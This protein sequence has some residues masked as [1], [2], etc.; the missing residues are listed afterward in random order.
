MI[1]FG[2]AC[3]NLTLG[4][5]T[6]HTLRL[7]KLGDADRLRGAVDANITAAQRIIAW[8]GANGYHLFRLG[9]SFIP[10]ASHENF[11]YD[12]QREHGEQLR[13]LA[14]LAR[15]HRQRLSMHPG[16]YCNPGSPAAGVV[17]RSLAELRYAAALI[18]LL[19]PDS[20]VIVIHLG[21]VFGD[22]ASAV[23]RFVD[24]LRPQRDILRH[25]ALE[26]DETSWSID[27]VLP[28]ASALGVPVIVDNLHHRLNPG[29][30]TLRGALAQA[31]TTWTKRPKV[32]LS[33]QAD[34][35]PVG[36]HADEI[37]PTDWSAFRRALP[38]EDVDVMVEAKKKEQALPRRSR[39][40]PPRLGH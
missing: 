26:N 32:H 7:A 21:G 6:N 37:R 27:Q 15:T 10:F 1:R 33:S 9:Q 18:D 11:S 4:E 8:N 2:Y 16:Q 19:N 25:L 5:T 3:L 31:F 30:L 29:R 24:N 14:A 22:R 34:A 13:S 36:A 23:E 38:H 12:W 40:G 28:V 39:P 35:K 17:E 20:G